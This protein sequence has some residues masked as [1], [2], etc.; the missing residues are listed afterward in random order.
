MAYVVPNANDPA[1]LAVPAG[2]P[3]G[4][5]P[6]QNTWSPRVGL[7]YAVAEKTV[8]RAGFGLYY[9]RM[10]GNP[11]FYTLNNPP[12]VGTTQYNYGNISNIKGG[13]T[14]SAPWGSMQTMDSHLKVPYAEQFSFGIQRE[15]PMR[16]FIETDY[17]GT[18]GRHLL[19]EPDINQPTWAVLGS[20][21]STINVNT[22]RPYAGF[23]TIQQFLSQATS[24][25][26]AL[27][28]LVTRRM[29]RI[30]FTGAYTFSKN[31]TDAAGDTESDVDP[32]NLHSTYGPAYSTS[33]AG[34]MDVRQAFHGTFM[35]NLPTLHNEKAWLRGPFGSW[36]LSG[37]LHLQTGPYLT[38][39]GNSPILGGTRVADYVGGPTLLPN[40]GPDGYFNRAAFT[41]PAAGRW[42]TAG[43]G[44]IQ[45]PGMQIYNFSMTK[46]FKFGHDGRMN[47]RVRADFF[48]AFNHTNFQQPSTNVSSSNYG[49][50]SGANPPRNIQLGMKLQF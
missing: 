39:T 22:I 14:V 1:V 45:G 7:A 32:Y 17:V 25:Y 46:F 31:L 21:P 12:Y 36:Q 11:T 44:D 8:I 35:L 13:A 28:V 49:T 2:A 41:A 20:V 16:L 6:G 4:M 29:G 33:S 10:Q 5:Y 19:S 38:V 18:L 43:V 50:I 3:R 48:N 15:L 24:N 9:D 27:Q 30:Y 42:G 23:S 40:P 47:L 37:I 26:N 34:S